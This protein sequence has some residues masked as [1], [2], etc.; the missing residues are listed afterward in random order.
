MFGIGW[1]EMAAIGALGLLVL[2]PED[3]AKIARELGRAYQWLGMSAL[4]ARSLVVRDL[5]STPRG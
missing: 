5:D 4:E 3:W 1:T 2:G